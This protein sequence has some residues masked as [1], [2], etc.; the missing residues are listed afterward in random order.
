MIMAPKK[1]V[2]SKKVASATPICKMTTTNVTRSGDTTSLL[3]GQSAEQGIPDSST[4][5]GQQE[6]AGVEFSEPAALDLEEKGPLPL[7]ALMEE[8]NGDTGEFPQTKLEIEDKE[9]IPF[10]TGEDALPSS[11]PST[12]PS[13][14]RKRRPTAST[15]PTPL[16][17]DDDGDW[18]PEHQGGLSKRGFQEGLV[19]SATSDDDEPVFVGESRAERA[20]G[21]SRQTAA[22]A[23]QIGSIFM[24]QKPTTTFHFGMPLGRTARKYTS[25][26]WDFF[27]IHRHHEHI[28]ICTICQAEVRR[29]K[30]G[31]HL[32]TGGQLAHLKGKHALLWEAHLKKMQTGASAGSASHCVA[33][34]G[35]EDGVLHPDMWRTPRP[36]TPTR[37]ASVMPYC[38][39]EVI[40]ALPRSC[41]TPVQKSVMAPAVKQTSIKAMFI[42]E[43]KYDQGHPVTRLYNGKLAKMLALDNLPFSLV[44]GEGFLEF[45]ET[46]CPK[47]KVP[48]QAY[49]SAVGVPEMHRTMLALVGSALMETAVHTIHLTTCM[50]NSGPDTDKVCITAHWVTFKTFDSRARTN[51]TTKEGIRQHATLA[52]FTIDKT[53]T[54]LKILD[55]FNA[56]VFEWL[57]PRG[58]KIGFV[59]TD[60]S[61]HIIRAMSDGGYFRVLCFAHCMNL[62]VQ[63]FLK[64]EAAVY[65]ILVICRR[66]CYHFS[67]SVRAQKQLTVLQRANALPVQSLIQEVP[68]CWTSTLYMLQ[69]LFEQYKAL[70][71]FV[72]QEKGD[73]SAKAMSLTLR[74]W[75]LIESIIKMLEPFEVVTQSLSRENATMSDAIPT[76]Q[77]LKVQLRALEKTFVDNDDEEAAGFVSS[78]LLRLET[79]Q[80][81][82]TEI[83]D[84]EEY[85]C[86]TIL[87]PRYRPGLP[88][89][90]LFAEEDVEK[91]KRWIVMRVSAHEN[92]RQQ[93]GRQ[94]R[95]VDAPYSST[96]AQP[97]TF[98]SSTAP[99]PQQ[100]PPLVQANTNSWSPMDTSS[101]LSTFSVPPPDSKLA[102]APSSAAPSPVLGWFTKVPGLTTS[103]DLEEIQQNL[104]SKMTI[105]KMVQEYM[106][107]KKKFPLDQ[108]PLIYWHG[109]LDEWPELSRLAIKYLSFPAASMSSKRVLNGPKAIFNDRR[110]SLP[111]QNDDLL[112]MLKINKH[113]LPNDYA[114]APEE[115]EQL[116][117]QF[118]ISDLACAASV[119]D[120]KNIVY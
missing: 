118:T 2:V 108:E 75:G 81:L 103:S 33:H 4:A 94:R 49:F 9:I 102:P 50:W 64:N 111:P 107:E 44:E 93:L 52:V 76:L 120:K 97:K 8:E 15:Y 1:S 61:S 63:D 80:K 34:E 79:N 57:Q 88:S 69:R 46:L 51:C 71:D 89:F 17:D 59:A 28:V 36:N 91:Y 35:D 96:D 95:T 66:I 117:N 78:L 58:L 5:S 19:A 45:V 25:H 32:G 114:A 43:T 21:T 106:N 65:K 6:L 55:E 11:P 26:V 53:Y 109:K 92:E 98:A 68:S 13:P 99:L 37:S 84:S 42:K 30:P 14:P 56:R 87:D 115:M 22:S 7:D 10:L 48:S 29:G 24:P 74:Q 67:H 100:Q 116:S 3:F 18:T 12:S 85:I 27:Y 60:N 40:P 20:E 72:M 23:I 113:F 101:S 86:A 82:N 54:A 90:M 31:K 112:T 62:I 73:A 104:L 38:N 110:S 77:M 16:S 70:N 119:D 47:W 39:R 83:V 41:P 105:E